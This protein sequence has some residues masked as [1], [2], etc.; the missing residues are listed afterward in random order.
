MELITNQKGGPAITTLLVR[1]FGTFL[2]FVR[3]YGVRHSGVRHSGTNSYEASTHTFPLPSLLAGGSVIVGDPCC[4]SI[5]V[6]SY[7]SSYGYNDY[8]AY[9]QHRLLRAVPQ[10][11]ARSL[12]PCLLEWESAKNFTTMALKFGYPEG[13]LKCRQ[14]TA[15]FNEMSPQLQ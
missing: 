10:N 13:T 14:C 4:F 2:H 3:H 7:V 5:S 6:L 8:K 15:Q 1:Y 9:C 11:T 12:P